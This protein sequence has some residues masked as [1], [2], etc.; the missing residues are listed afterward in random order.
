MSSKQVQFYS[1]TA[2]ELLCT[3][4]SKIKKFIDGGCI[5]WDPGVGAFLCSPIVG[6]NTRTYTMK[7]VGSGFECNCQFS[8]MRRK[9]GEPGVCSH[10][11]ALYEWFNLRNKRKGVGKFV[12]GN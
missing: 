5:S 3:Q 2:Q 9:R 8:V 1:H 10:I 12:Q 11:G 6:Y 4:Q 7:K